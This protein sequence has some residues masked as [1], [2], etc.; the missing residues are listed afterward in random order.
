MQASENV[1]AARKQMQEAR[2]AKKGTPEYLEY[3]N[4]QPSQKLRIAAAQEL[5]TAV[6][7][8]REATEALTVAGITGVG[9]QAAQ[10]QH[11]IASLVV[12][13]LQAKTTPGGASLSA[14]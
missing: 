5:S 9:L 11:A 3:Y 10:E 14:A 1:R 12:Q 2:L 7:A 4:N 8:L 6:T 13:R